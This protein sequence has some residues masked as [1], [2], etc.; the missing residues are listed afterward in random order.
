MQ[1]QTPDAFAEMDAALQT[2]NPG[3]I[4]AKDSLVQTPPA[5]DPKP[6]QITTPPAGE[7]EN[8]PPVRDRYRMEME[9]RA[10]AGQPGQEVSP[11]G[12]NPQSPL[13]D[14]ERLRL[15]REIK[16]RMQPPPVDLPPE[17][18]AGEPNSPPVTQNQTAQPADT[19]VAGQVVPRRDLLGPVKVSRVHAIDELRGRYKSPR[20]ALFMSL[21]LPGAGQ[22]YVGGSS[23]NYARAVAYLSA[24]IALGLGWYHYSVRLY[25][26]EVRRYTAYA[27]NHFSIGLLERRMLDLYNSLD[28]D[29]DQANFR[30][31]YRLEGAGREE[32]CRAIYGSETAFACASFSTAQ[33]HQQNFPEEQ[34]LG[35]SQ[36]QRGGFRN[37]TAL[38]RM[39][40]LE[41]Y[42]LGWVDADSVRTVGSL[43]LSGEIKDEL[44]I[45]AHRQRYINMRNQATDYADMQPYFLGAILL[46]HI[47]SA[48][49]A[50]LSARAHNA[51]LYQERLTWHQRIRLNSRAQLWPHWESHFNASLAF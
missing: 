47:V 17:A 19:A 37:E 30:Q 33:A 39:L 6:E 8:S 18:S 4:K 7:G 26:R 43:D 15:D 41:D 29:A 40:A 9:M 22:V 50:A 2:V 1:A 44:G 25:N 12:E 24:E 32:Y 23:W 28:S 35:E 45:S 10:R 11:Q 38:L 5:N 21:A 16:S 34:M 42:V 13:S 51:G 3:E 36:E 20:R 27:K 31:L 49:D 48:V 14:E 46:N